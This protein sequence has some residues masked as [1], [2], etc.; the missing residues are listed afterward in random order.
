[1][2]IEIILDQSNGFYTWILLGKFFHEMGVVHPC[3]VLHDTN[4]SFSCM[5]IK[6]NKDA[7]CPVTDVFIMHLLRTAWFHG[8]RH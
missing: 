3:P 8:Y 4:H 2:R 6:S 7:T 5:K 1:M